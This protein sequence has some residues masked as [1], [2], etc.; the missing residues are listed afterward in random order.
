MYLILWVDLAHD[1]KTLIFINILLYFGIYASRYAPRMS[2][3][4][5]LRPSCASMIFVQKNASKDTVDDE[6]L[7]S[8][9][10]YIFCFLPSALVLPFIFPNLF[11]FIRLTASR[12]FNFYLKDNVPGS[13]VGV[14]GLP[15]MVTLYICL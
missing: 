11:S 3:V 9:L 10:R 1:V 13:M 8:S 4:S 14:T 2:K 6:T 15:S 12:V 5:T 7:F